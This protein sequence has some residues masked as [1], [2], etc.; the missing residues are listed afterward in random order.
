MKGMA[1]QSQARKEKGSQADAFSDVAD[2]QDQYSHQNPLCYD[3]I[4]MTA[5]PG[6]TITSGMDSQTAKVKDADTAQH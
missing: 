3:V 6:L 2:I 4:L 1:M 5:V